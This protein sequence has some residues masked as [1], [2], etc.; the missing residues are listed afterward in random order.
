MK[1]MLN[2]LLFCLLFLASQA[3]AVENFSPGV[4]EQG[5]NNYNTYSTVA[6]DEVKIVA[7]LKAQDTEP[8]MLTTGTNSMN[9]KSGVISMKPTGVVCMKAIGCKNEVG[10]QGM[11]S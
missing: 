2:L 11:E 3:F 6:A 10:W 5:G 8:M 4:Q 7:V 1:K 9:D